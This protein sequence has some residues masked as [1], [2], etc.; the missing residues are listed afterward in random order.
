MIGS[1]GLLKTIYSE[2]ASFVF[3]IELTG[4]IDI[5][6]NVIYSLNKDFE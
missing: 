1:L 5:L 3:K 2:K 4:H 6:V